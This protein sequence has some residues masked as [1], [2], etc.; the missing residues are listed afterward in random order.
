MQ[1]SDPQGTPRPEEHPPPSGPPSSYGYQPAPTP[2]GYGYPPQRRT[3]SMAIAAMIVSLA[4]L[5]TCPVVGAV[6]IYLGN[7]ARAEIRRTGEEGDG[8]AV[9]GVVV[10]WVAIGL[11]VLYVCF[12]A[13]IFG[14]G[15]VPFFFA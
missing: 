1:P 14:M 8:M 4:S 7:R 10:G 5:F 2:P 9:A 13:A 11:T 3:N 12:F 15:T 6:G